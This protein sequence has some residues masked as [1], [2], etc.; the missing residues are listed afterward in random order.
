MTAL[1]EDAGQVLTGLARLSIA[2]NLG[3]AQPTF[4][5]ADW[6]EELGASFVTLK[7]NGNLRG[8]IGSLIAHQ[9]L[10]VD[11]R[12]NALAAAFDDPRFPPVSVE[13]FDQIH[14]EVSVL[15][16]PEPMSFTSYEDA[17]GQLRPG[18][19][20]VVLL[21]GGRRATFLP[22][23][24]EELSDPEQFMAHLMLKAG[25]PAPY[26]DDRVRLERYQ[27]TAFEE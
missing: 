3:L 9:S 12:Q 2:A 26:W 8:C 11:V 15:S 21:A 17:L 24:W 13:E 27:V 4:P 25:L 6:L 7:I 22:Q 19:D 20:G 16:P 18:I 23:V 14:L 10:G 5:S 1:P